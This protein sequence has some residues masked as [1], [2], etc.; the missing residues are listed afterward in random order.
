MC[1][2]MTVQFLTHVQLVT[3]I[4]YM[5]NK[6]LDIAGTMQEFDLTK[7]VTLLKY[8]QQQGLTVRFCSLVLYQAV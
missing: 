2:S 3:S 5:F 8:V 6:L 1:N 4:V 7:H